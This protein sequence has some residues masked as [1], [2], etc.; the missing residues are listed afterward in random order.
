MDLV[1][2][3][4]EL[5]RSSGKSFG[6]LDE[7]LSDRGYSSDEIAH[8]LSR[9]SAQW[10]P[11]DGSGGPAGANPSFRVL[12][13]WESAAL[14]AEAHGYLLR[15]R[16]LGI[17]DDE[18]LER[19]LDRIPPFGTEKLQLPEV[20]GLAGAVIFN[21]GPDYLGGDP[22]QGLDEEASIS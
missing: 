2:L 7:E 17:M 11:A 20:K 5:S 12:S 18:Q 8:A 15:L 10:K 1:V 16:E 22:F 14:G 13:N 3:V 21:L 19:L 6:E 4:A 9:I